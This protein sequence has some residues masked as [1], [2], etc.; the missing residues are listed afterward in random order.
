MGKTQNKTQ[1]GTQANFEQQAR[2]CFN[3]DFEIDIVY[4]I[5]A[6]RYPFESIFRFLFMFLIKRVSETTCLSCGCLS[7]RFIW[8]FFI[9]WLLWFWL[10]FFQKYFFIFSHKTK[11]FDD[12]LAMLFRAPLSYDSAPFLALGREGEYI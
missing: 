4:S 11:M 8:I 2:I 7:M 1:K 12:D 9:I 3:L 5:A 10:W 6:K